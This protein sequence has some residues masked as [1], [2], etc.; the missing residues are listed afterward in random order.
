MLRILQNWQRL[1]LIR[2]PKYDLPY[3]PYFDQGYVSVGDWHSSRP[4]GLND[5]N[6]RDTRFHG[7]KQEC[8]LHLPTTVE[9]AQSLDSSQL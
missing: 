5:E 1:I 8:G 6:E 2:A 7:V 3:H 9:E 4:L